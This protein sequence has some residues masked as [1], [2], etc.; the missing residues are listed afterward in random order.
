MD[1]HPK[2]LAIVM[3]RDFFSSEN[4]LVY[5]ANRSLLTRSRLSIVLL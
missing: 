1:N 3:L 4:H 2:I 5:Y